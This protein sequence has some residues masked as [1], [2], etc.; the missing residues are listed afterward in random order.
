MDR[1][2]AKTPGVYRSGR[3]HFCEFCSELPKL[4]TESICGIVLL[5]FEL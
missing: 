1:F 3:G 2:I 5:A 4:V